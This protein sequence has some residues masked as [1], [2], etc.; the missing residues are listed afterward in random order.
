[1]SSGILPVIGADGFHVSNELLQSSLAYGLG[2]PLS[3]GPEPGCLART[4]GLGLGSNPAGDAHMGN[5]FSR[6]HFNCTER[7]RCEDDL[8]FRLDKQDVH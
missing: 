1:M 4:G 6:V 8:R 7:G 5:K 3:G 2:P